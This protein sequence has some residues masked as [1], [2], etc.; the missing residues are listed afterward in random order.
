MSELKYKNITEEDNRRSH[1]SMQRLATDF[2]K[3][4]IKEHPAMKWV[5]LV[6]LFHERIT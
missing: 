3:L 2:R 5:M 4:F 6:F 1:E